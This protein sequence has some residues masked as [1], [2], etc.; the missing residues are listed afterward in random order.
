[1]KTI[2]KTNRIKPII[3]IFAILFL[4]GCG[5]YL[6]NPL[7]DKETGEDISL[8][9]IDFNFF[10]TSMTYKFL[11][12]SDGTRITKEAKI[13]FTGQNGNDI[14]TFAGEKKDIFYTSEGQ[15]ELTIDPNISI[16][17]NTTVEFAV[18]ID[19]EGYN[20]LAKGIQ[21]QNEGKKTYELYLSKIA[22]E[23]ETN[24]TGDVDYNNGDTTFYFNSNSSE[25]KSA[26]VE[27]KQY[28]IN[29]SLTISN[30]LK[31]Q[32]AYG[33]LLFNS[34]EEVIAE[35][36]LYPDN[37]VKLSINSFYDY[38]PG[39]ELLNIEGNVQSVLF[40]K[41]ETGK[42]NSLT[43]GGKVVAN[44][45]GGVINSFC[46]FIGDSEPELF[47]F[48][49]FE[50]SSWTMLG[51]EVVYDELQ[52]SYTVA[53][54]IDDSV[55]KIGATITFNSNTKTSF[56]IDADAYDENNNYLISMNFKGNFPETFVL[57]NIPEMAV[58]LVFRD[59]NPAFAP[60]PP[61]ENKNLCEGNYDIDV[62]VKDEFTE[63]QIVLKA[64]CADNPTIGIAPTYSAEVK[65]KSSEDSWQGITMTG[66]I[67][68][69]LGKPNQEYELR[70]LWE[71][72]WEYSTYF[73]TFDEDGNYLGPP[74]TGAKIESK[75]LDDGRIQIRID[76]IFSQQICDDL[77]W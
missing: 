51:K 24:L 16:S 56:S 68:D 10:K 5:E 49:N 20:N 14:V 62:N 66:G 33:N 17:V 27:G 25:T 6:D 8:L 45:N 64:L 9:I 31:F 7:I 12:A 41:L 77:G 42:L 50:N 53:Q 63:Y 74:E 70:L 3:L 34:S 18:N 67:T 60:I 23:E 36:Q 40:E 13:N 19:V 61:L 39:I 73:T 2:F 65:I 54:I 76:K 11:D 75:I 35:Y 52:F 28:E 43:V 22:D 47:G 1:M 44:F 26:L 72:E 48:A 57:E 55:C 37:F 58:K 69:V 38:K 30:L 4:S 21:I 32:D 59:N 15:L 46:N 71:G 29:Y